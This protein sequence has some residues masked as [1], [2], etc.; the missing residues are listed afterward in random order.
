MFFT[1]VGF[2]LAW[3]FFVLGVVAFVAI[4]V[5]VPAGTLYLDTVVGGK[6]L[7]ISIGIPAQLVLLGI[8][9]GIAAEISQS[10]RAL[11]RQSTD[12]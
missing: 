7:R 9:L 8:V 1:K 12:A 5:T 6:T 11:T 3:L 2:L 4:G 10:L